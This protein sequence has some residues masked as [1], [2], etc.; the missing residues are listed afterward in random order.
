MKLFDTKGMGYPDTKSLYKTLY[1]DLERIPQI[2][3]KLELFI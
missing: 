2:K 3:A 1:K